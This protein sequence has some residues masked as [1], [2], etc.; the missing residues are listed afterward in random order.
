MTAHKTRL[1]LQGSAV[2]WNEV[3]TPLSLSNILEHDVEHDEL[4]PVVCLQAP[5]RCSDAYK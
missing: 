3:H 1:I 5:K 2:E 4:N